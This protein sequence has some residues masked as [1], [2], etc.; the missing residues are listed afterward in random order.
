MY[1]LTIFM[2][3]NSFSKMSVWTNYTKLELGERISLD[4]VSKSQIYQ[5]LWIEYWSC[6]YVTWKTLAFKSGNFQEIKESN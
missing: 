6:L 4:F 1:F 5:V 3:K 2:L